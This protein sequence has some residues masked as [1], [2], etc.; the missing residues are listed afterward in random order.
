MSTS[1][2]SQDQDG[3]RET[4]WTLGNEN[5][6]SPKVAN[7]LCVYCTQ[8]LTRST[9]KIQVPSS[10]TL[11]SECRLCSEAVAE[12]IVLKTSDPSSQVGLPSHLIV[13]VS[14]YFFDSLTKGWKEAKT[15]EYMLADTGLQ[16]LQ[17]FA[18]FV[19]KGDLD[20][21][22][23]AKM[24]SNPVKSKDEK[25]LYVHGI[26]GYARGGKF[27][28]EFDYPDV[29]IDR[30]IGCYLLGE[31][32][33]SP[34]FCNAVMDQLTQY[35]R[36]FFNDNDNAVPLWNLHFAFGGIRNSGMQRYVADILNHSLSEKTFRLALELDYFNDIVGEEVCAAAFRDRE[37]KFRGPPWWRRNCT[38]HDHPAGMFNS[39]CKDE[40]PRLGYS[41][42][43]RIGCPL[44]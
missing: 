30:L 44:P 43:Y 13:K 27:E 15:G 40:W 3:C 34:G 39:P 11:H 5:P 22:D 42:R 33:Q 2:T 7:G 23:I 29:V 10:D 12:K 4:R 41:A 25:E 17:V 20:D 35:Y 14:K 26:T 36:S 9:N 32:L 1:N 38:Y 18:Q 31:Y 16:E 37:Q 19:R 6:S 8:L 28:I 24:L 21:V